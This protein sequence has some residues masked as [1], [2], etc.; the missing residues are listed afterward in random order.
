MIAAHK[1]DTLIL[2]IIHSV[3]GKKSH[4]TQAL[5]RLIIIHPPS[6]LIINLKR[7]TQ[8]GFAFSKNSKRI[9]FPLVLELD[10]FM[11][12][13]VLKSDLESLQQYR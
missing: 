12:H 11:I 10:D 5:K 13:S 3:E 9:K 7:F 2:L 8:M 4:R 6:N 1:D